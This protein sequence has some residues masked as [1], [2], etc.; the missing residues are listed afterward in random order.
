MNEKVDIEIFRRKLTVEMENLTPMEIAS[1]ARTVDEKM[2]EISEHNPK[3]ADSSKL[4]T[5][6]A[7]AFAADLAKAK[8]ARDTERLVIERKVDELNLALQTALAAA[9]SK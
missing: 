4:A 6:A 9:D 3:I 8:D 5:L 1:L 2:R 7:L